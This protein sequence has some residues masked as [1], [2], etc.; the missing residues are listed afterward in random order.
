MSAPR[1]RRVTSAAR[2][3]ADEHL[4][5]ELAPQVLGAV[6]RR[7]RDFA[8]AEDA[9][10]EAL[11]A[12]ALQWPRDG[13]PDNPRGWL[14]QVASRRMTDQLRSEIARRRRETR[15]VARAAARPT[16][17]RRR[18]TPSSREH[19]DTLM[20]LFMCCHP[21]LTPRV[22]D[23]ADAAR[24]RRPHDGR[25]RER[26]PRAR[27][28]DGAAH[29]PREAD[30]Q[31]SGVPFAMPT[32]QERA[33]SAS[34]RAARALPD[35][36]RGLHEQLGEPSLQRVDLA[37]EAHPARARGAPARCPTTPRSRACSR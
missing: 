30:D 2:P 21:A 4:L 8:A 12:A 14:F 19:D 16:S 5:R 33:R 28:D 3:T 32:E 36:Q 9:V 25:D 11:L 15:R 29:Q 27:G 18:R 31:A 35:L 10:Q 37:T 1:R 7:C 34:R 17:R 13:V 23:R 26:V 22:R 24:R 20:L 6:V